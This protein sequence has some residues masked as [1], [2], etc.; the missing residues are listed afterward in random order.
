MSFDNRFNERNSFRQPGGNDPAAR[1]ASEIFNHQLQNAAYDTQS[2][3]RGRTGREADNFVR[4]VNYDLQQM[5]AQYGT[6]P[7]NYLSTRHTGGEYGQPTELVTMTDGRHSKAIA[8]VR[9][10]NF[11]GQFN[12][13]GVDQRYNDGRL[14]Q[15]G[16]DPRFND[17]R[18]NDGRFNDGRFNDGR[19]ND[20][21][22]S[23]GRFN[24]GRFNQPYDQYQSRD[25]VSRIANEIYCHNLQDAE[26]D[27]RNYLR[28]RSG[29]DAQQFASDVNRCLQRLAQRNGDEQEQL[30]NYLSVHRA[31]G[32]DGRPTEVVA[33]TDGYD[34][35]NIAAVSM[36]P[37]NRVGMNFDQYQNGEMPGRPYFRQ[38]IAQASYDGDYDQGFAPAYPPGMAF[39]FGHRY[40]RYGYGNYNYGFNQGINPAGYIIG[41][42]LSRVFRI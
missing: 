37:Y 4:N 39:G 31:M 32:R 29:Q 25:A 1:V 11:A 22:F 28:G 12:Q 17:G 14:S 33:L 13:P 21:R 2:I 10:D 41:S 6:R 15:S 36:Y 3:L 30:A 40:P 5:A 34:S 35:K 24:D 26:I 19:F 7:E 20:G 27:T 16:L 42:V 38:P 18:F 23:D 9:D 8:Q